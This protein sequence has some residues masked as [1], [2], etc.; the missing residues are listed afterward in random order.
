[1]SETFGITINRPAG[2]LRRVAVSPATFA[3]GQSGSAT[4]TLTT[5]APAGGAVVS[6]SS[7]DAAA[8]SVP[9]SVTVH[10]GATSATFK[11]TAGTVEAATPVTLTAT[12]SGVSET[13]SVTIT[14]VTGAGL[15]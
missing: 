5:G 13:A 14:P 8:A 1:M 9:A 11:V 7:S 4:V 12:Y 3:S 2:V 10:H 6:L 15:R